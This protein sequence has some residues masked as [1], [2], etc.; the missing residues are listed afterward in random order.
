[1]IG[2]VDEY[3][4]VFRVE[5]AVDSSSIDSA[6]LELETPEVYAGVKKS[7]SAP[8]LIQKYTSA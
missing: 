7:S 2:E 3:K 1:M 4:P 8:R 6:A 5:K